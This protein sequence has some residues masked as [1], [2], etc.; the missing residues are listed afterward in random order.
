[1]NAVMKEGNQLPASALDIEDKLM[2]AWDM[3][4]TAVGDDGTNIRPA[5]QAALLMATRETL[6]TAKQMFDALVVQQPYS[7]EVGDAL[8]MS[9]TGQYRIAAC[10]DRSS[11][12]NDASCW[13]ANATGV[14]GV[15]CEW[16][17]CNSESIDYIEALYGAMN[18][19]DMVLGAI[20]AFVAAGVITSSL[21]AIR[22]SFN[23]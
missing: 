6:L 1:M 2:D 21:D 17:N 9:M 12:F 15:V 4:K 19:I 10:T 23:G 20:R 18:L 14:V 22:C 5:A 11:L 13:L 8:L 7:T 3:L 16:M